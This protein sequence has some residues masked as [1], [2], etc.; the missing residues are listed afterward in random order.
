VIQVSQDERFERRDTDLF[1]RV[2]V[3]LTSAVLGGEALVAT[4]T[5]D[6]KL[7]IPPGTQPGQS[8]RVRG[9][10]MPHLRDPA[11]HGDLF[12]RVQVRLPT[13]LPEQARA[14]FEQLRAL[15]T[16]P[17]EHEAQAAHDGGQR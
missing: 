10:G 5:G 9:R 14:L 17:T 3:P 8:I 13:H 4:L 1:T 11:K 16:P 12:V 7:K 6:I 2:M 15:E